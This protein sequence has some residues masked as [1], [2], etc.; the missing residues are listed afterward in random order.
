VLFHDAASVWMLLEDS[1]RLLWC[2]GQGGDGVFLFVVMMLDASFDSMRTGL[3][4]A[5]RRPSAG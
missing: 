4:Y 1:W 5:G 2:F 3:G